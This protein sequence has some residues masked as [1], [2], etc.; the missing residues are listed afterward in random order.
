MT[1]NITEETV[2]VA[3][4]GKQIL[5][6]EVKLLRKTNKDFTEEYT[7]L[8]M[9]SDGRAHIVCDL[10]KEDEI[11][12]PFS[13]GH[14]LAPEIFEYLEDQANYMSA[15]TPLTIEFILDRHNQ[16]LQETVS[17]L[18]R[19]HYRFDFAEDRS[20]ITKNRTLAWLLAW[21]RDALVLVLWLASSLLSQRFQEI[22]SIFSWVFI[23]E[24][25]D[26]FVFERLSIGQK[27]KPAMPKWRPRSSLFRFLKERGPVEEYARHR[28]PHRIGLTLRRTLL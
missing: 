27:S 12:K 1:E 28:R 6:N 18:Y 17:K 22:V 8:F 11:F 14:A 25:C 19:S 9:Q 15:G 21:Y 5:S 10:R 24:S 20:E 2:A 7:K 3:H 4:N 16:D 26:R 23:W 13:A